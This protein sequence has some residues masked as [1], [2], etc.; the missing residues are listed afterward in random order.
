MSAQDL[1]KAL[2]DRREALEKN[3]DANRQALRDF[4]R[5]RAG[6]FS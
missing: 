4:E 2:S 1:I 6:E 3:R 5:K